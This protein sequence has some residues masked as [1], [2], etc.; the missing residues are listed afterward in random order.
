MCQTKRNQLSFLLFTYHTSLSSVSLKAGSSPE[1]SEAL[2]GHSFC[3]F[4]TEC[5]EVL[6]QLGRLGGEGGEGRVRDKERERERR[7]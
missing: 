3:F 4:G 5:L 1:N 6:G 2:S 7:G